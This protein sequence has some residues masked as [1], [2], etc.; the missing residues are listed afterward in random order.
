MFILPIF[1]IEFTVKPKNAPFFNKF[2]EYIQIMTILANIMNFQFL[3]KRHFWG[4]IL[5]TFL[6]KTQF[7]QQKHGACGKV[8]IP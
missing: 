6:R 2:S 8:S 7:F 1:A 3:T 5:G 4:P